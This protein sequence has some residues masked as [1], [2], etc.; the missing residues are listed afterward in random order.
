MMHFQ[1][2]LDVHA[3]V[4]W[5]GHSVGGMFFLM[6]SCIAVPVLGSFANP[7]EAIKRSIIRSGI[8]WYWERDPRIGALRDALE[9][10]GIITEPVTTM[11]GICKAC[12]HG[13]GMALECDL[14][15]R[16]R[17]FK[18]IIVRCASCG[19]ALDR[20]PGPSLDELAVE[21]GRFRRRT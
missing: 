14:M 2:S 6:F 21:Y 3:W 18:G 13:F 20:R 8:L 4:H 11:D 7:L 19:H 16:R 12:E 15:R 10:S 1:F 9:A 5:M 17:A